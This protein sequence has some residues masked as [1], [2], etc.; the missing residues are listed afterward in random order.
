MRPGPLLNVKTRPIVVLRTAL[1]PQCEVIN[2]AADFCSLPA[3]FCATAAIMISSPASVGD[4]ASR[5]AIFSVT[6]LGAIF[7]PTDGSLPAGL[8]PRLLSITLRNL[9]SE[10]STEPFSQGLPRSL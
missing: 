8:G 4:R 1:P 2:S 10:L 5:F 7:A 9:R 6:P 3:R